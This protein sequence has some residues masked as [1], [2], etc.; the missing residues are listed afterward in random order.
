[1]TLEVPGKREAATD[2]I[3][4]VSLN[5]VAGPVATRRLSSSQRA[6]R[7]RILQVAVGLLE[8][9]D[10]EQIQIRQVAEGAGVALATLYRYFPSKEQLYAH[11][12]SAW[13]STFDLK[14]RIRTRAQDTDATRLLYVLRRTVRSYERSPNFY[15]LTRSLD[16]ATDPVVRSVFG[17]F[18]DRFFGVMED[19]LLDTD[20]DDVGT[21]VLMATSVLGVLLNDWALGGLPVRRVYDELEKSITVLFTGPRQRRRTAI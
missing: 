6:R 9:R 3:G 12:L 10:Y 7:E 20:E 2:G 11:A 16:A 21:I 18:K 4:A 1:M 17:A 15:R 19:V 14:V 8:D 5:D 13:G